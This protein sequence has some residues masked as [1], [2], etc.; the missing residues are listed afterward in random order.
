[1]KRTIL[2][3]CILNSSAAGVLKDTEICGRQASIRDR[4]QL[5]DAV[6]QPPTTVIHEN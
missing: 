1:M 5:V 4:R 6:S 2:T 3:W